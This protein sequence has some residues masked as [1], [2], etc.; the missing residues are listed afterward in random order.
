M[1]G[2]LRPS[3]ELGSSSKSP[4][5]ATIQSCRGACMLHCATLLVYTLTISPSATDGPSP[6]QLTG[7]CR[8]CGSSSPCSCCPCLVRFLGV[9]L[10]VQKP[11]VRTYRI[12]KTLPQCSDL[13]FYTAFAPSPHTLHYTDIIRRWN[14]LQ[15]LFSVF[16]ID[17]FLH[18]PLLRPYQTIPSPFCNVSRQP[19]LYWIP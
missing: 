5:H 1:F 6:M 2:P 4:A 18:T 12:E 14:A 16:D 9:C 7:A 17:L 11:T 3:R 10:T 15:L 8:P 19:F 13:T